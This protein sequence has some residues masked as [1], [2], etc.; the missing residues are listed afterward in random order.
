M[1][2]VML[3]KLLLK[4]VLFLGRLLALEDS[5]EILIKLKN[6]KTKQIIS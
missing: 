6:F 5:G 2:R 3:L 1:Y 4:K